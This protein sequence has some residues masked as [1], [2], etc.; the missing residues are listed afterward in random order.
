MTL[1]IIIVA[2]YALYRFY[3]NQEQARKEAQRKAEAE[4][5]KRDQ[6]RIREEWKQRVAEAKIET[7]RLIKLEREQMRI[8]RE[9]ERQAKQLEKHEEQLSKMQ[10]Q[11]DQACE[12]IDN[13]L[14]KIE[15]LQHYSEFLQEQRDK[16]TSNSAEYFKWQNKLST[17]DDKI[18]RLTKQKNKAM[19]VKEQAQR[20]LEVA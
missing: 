20:K 13:I 3:A 16:C 14:Y 15:E 1:F 10:F 7:D 4:R 17:V 19:F 12:D 9:Q 5:I 6:A 2:A 18:Y 8:A 11:L